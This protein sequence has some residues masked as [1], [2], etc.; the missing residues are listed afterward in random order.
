MNATTM[1][2]AGPTVRHPHT[3][4][5][6]IVVV[7]CLILTSVPPLTGPAERPW[8]RPVFWSGVVGVTIA[9]FA[10]AVPYWWQAAGAALFSLAFLTA[11]AYF[12]TPYIKIGGK[13]HAFWISDSG[14][15]AP[16]NAYEG[17]V[18]ARKHWWATVFTV[19][20]FGGGLLVPGKQPWWSIP[21]V[22]VILVTASFGFGYL[23]A[24]R[25]FPIAR[26]QRLQFV[27]LAIISVGS[28]TLLYVAGYFIGKRWRWPSRR[29]LD[30]GAHA[31][32]RDDSR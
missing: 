7:G 29:T 30:Y 14:G 22:T 28:F 19:T 9:V 15:E 32:R 27:I 2:A 25:G 18:T 20:F 23:D 8:K 24:S 10:G 5:A 4:I 16:P 31:Q 11:A 1:L 12:Y 26:G 6:F 13:I 21:V 3:L 17:M